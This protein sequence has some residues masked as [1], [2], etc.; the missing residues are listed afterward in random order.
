[1]KNKKS[2]TKFLKVVAH[3][4]CRGSFALFVLWVAMTSLIPPTA[5]ADAPAEF[6]MACGRVFKL[7]P[8][9]IQGYDGTAFV[10]NVSAG[11]TLTEPFTGKAKKT[12]L[13]VYHN[14]FIW[15]AGVYCEWK[16]KFALYDSRSWDKT[17]TCAE[18]IAAGRQVA[19]IICP[20]LATTVDTTGKKLDGAP[21]GEV[22]L[23]PPEI[24]G[25]T[26]Y[27]TFEPVTSCAAGQALRISGFLFGVKLPTVYLE[28]EKAGVVK[29]LKLKMIR[30]F[31]YVD[32]VG[33]GSCMDAFSGASL[34]V[35]QTPKSWPRDWDQS[36]PHN[37]VLDNKIGRTTID[38][39]S[40]A[41]HAR[42]PI[43]EPFPMA[44]VIR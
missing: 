36:V 15:P 13:T 29:A 11:A 44:P 41:E 4:N 28:Y 24:V 37:L 18:N 2:T 3:K 34:V 33:N 32:A 5:A 14:P 25:V 26:D 20:L 31:V 22:R 35:V 16:G 30:T 19:A 21:A 6:E 9:A 39:R 43:R 38:F 12:K 1:M 7:V 42:N 23:L 17:Q 10:K 40:K 8:S 27:F